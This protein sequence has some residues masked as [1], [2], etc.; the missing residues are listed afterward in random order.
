MPLLSRWFARTALI[1]LFIGFSLGGLI[2][3]A[4]AG[5]VDARVWVWLLPHADILIVGWLIQLAMGVSYWI[6]PRIREAGRGRVA[7]AWTAYV[8][9]NI[10]LCLG[11]GFS[12]LDYWLQSDGWL[13]RM[14]IPGLLVQAI[15][16]CVYVIYAWPRILP[17]ITS[18]DWKH[19][20][21]TARH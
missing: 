17:T 6:L 10:G 16:M 9:L 19:K 13:S 20:S 3:S 18:S 7:L 1:Y 5:I 12:L 8:L 4:K 2:L 11:A 21:E 15:A 14:F